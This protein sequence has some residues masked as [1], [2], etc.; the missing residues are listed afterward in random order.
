MQG[1]SE[2]MTAC[3]MKVLGRI[4]AQEPPHLFFSLQSSPMGAQ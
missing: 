1:L 4:L 2:E 3:Q